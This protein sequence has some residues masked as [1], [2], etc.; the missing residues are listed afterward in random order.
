M[1]MYTAL[2]M[3]KQKDLR[4]NYGSYRVTSESQNRKEFTKEIKGEYPDF[5][6]LSLERE[7]IFTTGVKRIH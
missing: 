4:G 1:K 7:S 5:K 3:D 6:I 2:I